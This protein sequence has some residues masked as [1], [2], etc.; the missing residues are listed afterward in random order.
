M[1]H[2]T[3]I[4]EVPNTGPLEVPEYVIL[5]FARAWDRTIHGANYE[6]GSGRNRKAEGIL[7]TFCLVLGYD[8]DEPD[9]RDDVEMYLDELTDE[10]AEHDDEDEEL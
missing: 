1:P 9:H 4:I 10:L 7:D 3:R 5:G 2:A 6:A 8:P